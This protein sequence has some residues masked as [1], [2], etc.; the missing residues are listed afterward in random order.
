M[1][2]IGVFTVRF[3]CRVLVLFLKG[4]CTLTRS[5]SL[6][7]LQRNSCGLGPK[8]ILSYMSPKL[9]APKPNPQNLD[10]RPRPPLETEGQN[11]VLNP[12]G[13][14]IND[15]FKPLNPQPSTLNPQPS[16]LNPQPSTLNPQPSTLNPQPS[17]LNPQPSTLNPQP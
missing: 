13:P 5:M 9:K 16:T 11:L 12:E 7:G 15:P 1:G 3:S 10:P 6:F 14:Q 17:T 8:R 4:P 2:G